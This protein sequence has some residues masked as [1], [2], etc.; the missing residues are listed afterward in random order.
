MQ[1]YE[2]SAEFEEDIA[3]LRE[4]YFFRLKPNPHNW[5]IID[6]WNYKYIVA[7][8]QKELFMAVQKEANRMIYDQMG[9]M[10]DGFAEIK[11]IRPIWASNAGIEDF[12]KFLD[13]LPY[14]QHYDP[15][16]NEWIY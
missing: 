8:S 13:K 16:L 4:K 5:P 15:F 10:F 7:L 3:R 2:P 9:N 1:K 12:K 6:K 14:Q 11:D